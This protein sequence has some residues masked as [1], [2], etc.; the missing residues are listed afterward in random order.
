MLNDMTQIRAVFQGSDPAAYARRYDD[1][2]VCTYNRLFPLFVESVKHSITESKLDPS[3]F[4]HG[5]AEM[6]TVKSAV[7]T[8]HPI[9]LV[10]C[11][12][13]AASVAYYHGCSEASD[14]AFVDAVSTAIEQLTS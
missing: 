12:T 14:D 9:E 13:L 4:D 3:D 11:R 10:L 1:A 5:S 2:Y 8:E 7:L 6:L